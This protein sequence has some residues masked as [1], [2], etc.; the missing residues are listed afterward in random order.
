MRSLALIAA[1]SLSSITP[2]FAADLIRLPAR[3][4][5]E[6]AVVSSAEGTESQLFMR[7]VSIDLTPATATMTIGTLT[8]H[9]NQ[10]TE[11][12]RLELWAT[13]IAPVYGDSIDARVIAT[14][15]LPFTLQ[16]GE[17]RLNLST[18]ARPLDP[19]SQGAFYLTVALL[20][21]YP[22]QNDYFYV[23]IFTLPGARRFGAAIVL[24]GLPRGLFQKIGTGGAADDFYVTNVGNL[25]GNVQI[26]QNGDF[27]VMNP[28][29]FTIAP[30]TRERVRLLA[31]SR[32]EG[33]YKGEALVSLNGQLVY[34][35]PI[36]L[37]AANPPSG[38]ARLRVLSQRVDVSGAAGT[39]PRGSVTFSNTGTATIKGLV[40]SDSQWLVPVDESVAIAPGGTA[41]VGFICRRELRTNSE[42]PGVSGSLS[43]AYL[44]GA[45]SGAARSTMDTPPT[46]LAGV[47]VTDTSQPSTTTGAVPPLA[48]GEVAVMMP[49]MG[50]VVGSVGEFVSDLSIV[51]GLL[52]SSVGDM[53]L[54][55]SSSSASKAGPTTTVAPTQAI[56][57][58]DVV[59]GYF[60]ETGQVGTIQV[61]TK[62]LGSLSMAA[63]VFNKSNPLGTYGTA[64]P[65][66]RT[67]RAV[68]PGQKLVISGLRQDA[69]AHTNIYLQ[70]M[71]GTGPAVALI[72]FYDAGGS[73][74]GSVTTPGIAPFALGSLFSVVPAGAVSAVVTPTSGKLVAYATPVD[75]ASGDTWAVA[76]WSRQFQLSGS[77]RSIVPVAGAVAGANNSNF[78]TDL[79]ITNTGFGQGELK[80]TYFPSGAS[81]IAAS[82]NLGPNQSSTLEDVAPSFFKLAGT[83]VG[84]ISVE[85]VTSTFVVTSR[86]YTKTT[87]NPATFGTGVATVPPSIGLKLGEARTFGGLDDS[88]TATVS[89]KQGATFR[90][91]VGLIEVSGQQATARVSVYFAT[92]TQLAAG[93]ANATKDYVVP[94]NGYLALNGIVRQIVGDS[95]EIE[96][97]DLHGVSVKVEVVDGA[98]TIIPYVTATDNGTNDTLLRT[99]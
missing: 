76:D 73:K 48:Q 44:L 4:T 11:A 6:A 28:T 13:P 8:S 39:N 42:L 59:T 86:T 22:G 58:A 69:S 31:G 47:I 5:P 12:L 84:W 91:N 1:L 53:K 55:Y 81:P 62:S 83:S 96:F 49:G 29:S 19:P 15:N 43:L 36:R 27:F 7:G 23:D 65:A 74:I 99:E 93:G 41:T 3:T 90:T 54:Y 52:G 88:T 71:S 79:S 60:G 18:G 82:V 32:S 89:S 24:S 70:E 87:G 51:N 17:T 21:Y 50:H 10:P 98:G 75:E 26:S 25:P 61:R 46:S 77:T 56:N 80:L 63:N 35:V 14:A 16:A 95:R 66:F 94:P 97:G 30:G 72:D 38:E 2:A 34:T 45:G 33:F 57:L 85:P 37:L 68:T 78:R 9:R 20:E 64:I 92:G 67:D 40:I